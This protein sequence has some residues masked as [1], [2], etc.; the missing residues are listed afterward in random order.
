MAINLTQRPALYPHSQIVNETPFKTI[1]A[2]FNGANATLVKGSALAAADVFELINIPAGAFVLS[3][4][5]KV[6]T[7]E[8]ATCTYHLGDG[9]DP[10]GF[11]ASANGNAA[12]FAS[13][14]NGTTTPAFGVGKFY[15]E[16]DTLDLTLAT[17]TA[18]NVAVEV[19]VTFAMT[20]PK[21]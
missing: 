3:V 2:E 17:G 7:P 9:V 18:A 15:A 4:T 20:A 1:S 19:S 11:V 13:S 5:H 16:A 6:V 14:F 8:G 12:T 10:D 21:V